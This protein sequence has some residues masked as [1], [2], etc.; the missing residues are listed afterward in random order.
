MCQSTAASRRP[1][2]RRTLG[3]ALVA[4]LAFGCLE[5]TV[6]DSCDGDG[7]GVV[8]VSAPH[9]AVASSSLPGP[10]I[11][12]HAA[13]V[14]HCAHAHAFRLP[15]VSCGAQA[16]VGLRREFARAEAMPGSPVR[17]QGLRP[18]IVLIS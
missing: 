3:S 5:V 4:V 6:A 2:F 11:P 10:S 1:M 8:R 15:P 7:F 18:P 17:E 14:C 13:H 9:G 12:T 16:C